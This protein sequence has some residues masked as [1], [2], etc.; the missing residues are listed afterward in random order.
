MADGSAAAPARPAP[1]SMREGRP[2]T[3]VVI[4]A[5]NEERFIGSTVIL[6]RQYADRVIVVDDGSVDATAAIARAAGAVVVR[7]RQNRGKGA[8]LNTGLQKACELDPD[9]VI[10]VDAD[11]QHVVAEVTRVA[12]PVLDGKAD[13]VVGSRY[14]QGKSR[15]PA[16]RSVGHRMFNFM[17]NRASGIAVT[18]SQ[19]GFRAFSARALHLITFQSNGFSVESEMQFIARQHGLRVVEAPITVHYYDAPKRSV[20]AHGFMVLNGL[21]RLMGQYR[22]L[23]FLGV[24]AVFTLLLASAW[25]LWAVYIYRVT[26]KAAVGY[27]LISVTLFI[28]GQAILTT[29]FILHSIRALLLPII[30]Q[31]RRR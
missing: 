3:V 18:D 24:P 5:Y 23:L 9:V 4:P 31:G 22:P 28:V 29:A 12:A 7:H 27:A 6:A 1:G 26:Q 25:G 21:L 8:A 20:F 16:Y 11:G 10:A 17:T 2:M 19:S 30:K 15:V 14:L 13:I